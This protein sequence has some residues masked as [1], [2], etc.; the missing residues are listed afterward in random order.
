MEAF[1]SLLVGVTVI[2]ETVLSIDASYSYSYSSEAKPG[3]S[4]M[5]LPPV[6]SSSARSLS[7][8][9]VEAV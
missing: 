8:A 3:V 5:A 7:V 9:S 2:R 1:T 6:A 4:V